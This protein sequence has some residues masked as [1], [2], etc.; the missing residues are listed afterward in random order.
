MRNIRLILA[1]DGTGYHGFQRQQESHGPTIQGTLEKIWQVL[2]EEEISISTAG[3]TDAGVHAAGQVV[4]FRSAVGIPSENIAKAFNSLLPREIRILNAQDETED[5]HARLSAQWKRYDYLIYNKRIL[6]VFKRLYTLHEPIKLDTERMKS[7]ALLL[8]GRHN[9]RFFA[10]SG[11]SSKTFER[12]LYCCQVKEE[13]DLLRVI[14]IGDGFLYKM[15]RIIAGTLLQ[16]G[17]G[18][19]DV[20][21]IPQLLVLQERKHVPIVASAQGLT[22]IYVHYGEESPWQV[23]PELN[24]SIVWS[25]P[26]TYNSWRNLYQNKALK[27]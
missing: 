8:E 26:E 19:L 14:C 15:V 9:F 21:E 27:C 17:K 22:L 12:N 16:V 11:G 24:C 6:D 25:N 3:R 20:A 10:A 1:Y 23:Y 5:F 18:R 7:A 4:N 13:G 2:T